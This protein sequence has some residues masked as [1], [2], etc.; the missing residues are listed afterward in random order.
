MLN[1]SERILQADHLRHCEFAD[2][3][4]NSGCWFVLGA[5]GAKW[6]II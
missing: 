4:Y 2:Q 5:V 6:Y 1:L 3:F